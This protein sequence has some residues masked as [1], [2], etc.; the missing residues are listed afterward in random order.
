MQ[1]VND[2]FP[3]KNYDNFRNF[4]KNIRETEVRDIEDTIMTMLK[5]L[6][7]D[8]ST[9]LEMLLLSTLMTPQSS[10]V[11]SILAT[12]L[13]NIIR[14]FVGY[15]SYRIRDYI[16]SQTFKLEFTVSS[17]S[18]VLQILEA[19]LEKHKENLNVTKYCGLKLDI[20]SKK[21]MMGY[22]VSLYSSNNIKEQQLQ[23]NLIPNTKYVYDYNGESIN[24]VLDIP[25]KSNNYGGYVIGP[26]HDDN[27]TYT[28]VVSSKKKGL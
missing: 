24:I 21:R 9:V 7:D 20:N 18:P 26:C 16:E 8:F 3:L 25:E 2:V 4:R 23:F 19:Y 22:D 5:N 27:C 12:L 14:Y 6:V 11:K 10:I 1:S 13:S 15:I 17:Y 28:L